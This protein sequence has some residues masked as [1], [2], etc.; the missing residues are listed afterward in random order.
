MPL[1]SAVHQRFS[2][3]PGQVYI[4]ALRWRDPPLSCPRGQSHDVS[5]WGMSHERPGVKRYGCH[6]GQHTCNDL[7]HTRWAQR[8][9]ALSYWR[10]AT[11]LLCRSGSSRRPA[12]EVGVHPHQRSRVGVG[13]PCGPVP[14]H[15]SPRGGHCGRG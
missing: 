10:L 8:T 1:R 13:A 4:H 5:P 9:R 3:E 7:T 11:L 2:P 6:G 12:R 14:G 15:G